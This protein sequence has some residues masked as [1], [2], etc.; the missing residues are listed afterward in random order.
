MESL[1]AYIR[2]HIIEFEA[3]NPG[4]L[5]PLEEYGRTCFMHGCDEWHIEN[6]EKQHAFVAH[7]DCDIMS[8]YNVLHRHT[9]DF[10]DFID[11]PHPSLCF[12]SL[13]PLRRRREHEESTIS[14][15]PSTPIDCEASSS[16]FSFEFQVCTINSKS[17]KV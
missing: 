1:K 17:G 6:R 3:S 13:H 11:P 16:S 8:D 4:P 9:A 2:Q 15:F 7:C 14:T 5:F 12:S 10:G